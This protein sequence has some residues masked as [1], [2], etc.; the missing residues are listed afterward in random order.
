VGRYSE[1]CSK[2]WIAPGKWELN[3]TA[4]LVFTPNGITRLVKSKP[5]RLNNNERTVQVKLVVPSEV[6][7]DTVPS[8]NLKLNA[9]HVHNE[10][11]LVLSAI[12]RE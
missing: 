1:H 3:M 6:F 5:S 9:D 10:A 2:R 7:E 8:F 12:A 4:F 11:D